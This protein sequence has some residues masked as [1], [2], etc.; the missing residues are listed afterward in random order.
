MSQLIGYFYFLWQCDNYMYYRVNI[1]CT[2]HWSMT[3]IILPV[4][5]VKVQRPVD[6]LFRFVGPAIH[7]SPVQETDKYI[8]F[9]CLLHLYRSSISLHSLH[10]FTSATW[11]LK[12]NSPCDVFTPCRD[13]GVGTTS[14]RLPVWQTFNRK[15]DGNREENVFW[16]RNEWS[17]KLYFV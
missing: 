14:S 1:T 16:H 13:C 2:L 7:I 15:R 10:V 17:K 6:Y 4:L 5:W 11:C 3:I 12:M 9:A 8:I